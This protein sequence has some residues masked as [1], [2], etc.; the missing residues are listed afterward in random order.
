[1]YLFLDDERLPEEAAEY[2][3]PHY[4]Y[5]YRTN[6]WHVVRN[7]EQ[8]VEHIANYGLP[9]FISFDHDLA[10]IHYRL[11]DR[12]IPWHIYYKTDRNKTEYTGFDCAKWLVDYCMDNKLKIPEYVVHS[13]NT[14]GSEN[15]SIYLKN[16][17]KHMNNV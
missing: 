16:A 8:F 3:H 13:K 1:M 15:I 2:M 10:D 17:I 12:N 4:G 11:V 6:E 9:E 5:M 7:Y 14:V